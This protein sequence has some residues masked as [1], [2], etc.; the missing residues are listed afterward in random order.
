MA[1]GLEDE[2]QCQICLD[3]FKDPVILPCSH[4]FCKACLQ[5]WWTDSVTKKC[6]VCNEMHLQVDIHTLPSNLALRKLCEAFILQR[7]K[8]ATTPICT[9]HLEKLKLFCFDHREP[10][11]LIC[12]ASKAHNNHTFKPIDEAAHDYREELKETIGHL[13]KKLK[14]C[15]LLFAKWNDLGKYIEIQAIKTEKQIKEEFAKLH[16]F[17]HREEKDR[18]AFLRKE[19]VLKKN[20]ITERACIISKK[21]RTL[22]ETIKATARDIDSEDVTFLTKYKDIVKRVECAPLVDEQ[23]ISTGALIDE[24]KHLSNLR[25][26]T[27]MKMKDM[28]TYNPVILNPNTA[29]ARLVVSD[30]LS[31]VSAGKPV[32]NLPQN[33]ERLSNYCVLGSEGLTCGIHSWELNVKNNQNWALGVATL[34]YQQGDASLTQ[35]W[36]LGHCEGTYSAETKSGDFMFLSLK[37]Q[38]QRIKVHLNIDGGKLSFFDAETHLCTFTHAFTGD[39]LYPYMFTEDETPL[40]ILPKNIYIKTEYK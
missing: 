34:S 7:D 37:K 9:A 22:N 3:I 1:S 5:T 20:T 30:D 4:S 2:L 25:L 10:V 39:K 15:E 28:I 14:Q 32:L 17:L 29:G 16:H 6:P 23:M 13:K 33:P 36:R 31:T 21:M 19:N 27:W 11:C 18:L 12:Q 24:A 8:D 40:E 26:N 38:P 35:I